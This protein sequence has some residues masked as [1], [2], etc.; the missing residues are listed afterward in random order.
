MKRAKYSII[1]YVP[2]PA[3][4]E[5]LNIGIL[6]WDHSSHVLELDDAAL[7]RVITENP[8]LAL[9]ALAGLQTSLQEAIGAPESG[10]DDLISSVLLSSRGFPVQ[11]SEPRMTSIVEENGSLRE[12]LGRLLRRTVRPRRRSGAY[13]PNLVD[14]I[15][16]HF[17][18]WI[19]R[20]LI[21]RN[22]VFESSRSGSR[23]VTQFLANSGT[24]I[25]FDT[26]KLDLKRDQAIRDRA[27]AEAWKI[28]DLSEHY[29]IRYIVH[30]QT[31]NDNRL[32]DAVNASENMIRTAGGEP[33]VKLDEALESVEA[34]LLAVA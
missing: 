9:D 17:Q 13:V 24:N 5:A 19:E 4:G 8:W 33:Y 12:P 20:D 11:F 28:W 26:L 31:S 25:A 22:Y 6:V 15:D 10:G 21:R 14:R 29:E 1:R 7:K 32:E 34:A 23:Y 30:L 18:K 16:R 3:R 2:D 27:A